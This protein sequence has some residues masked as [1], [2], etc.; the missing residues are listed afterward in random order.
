[1]FTAKEEE[2]VLQAG[3]LPESMLKANLA[4][5]LEPEI[6]EP[7]IEVPLT[8]TVPT[9]EQPV[10]ETVEVVPPK[11]KVAAK[12][13]TTIVLALSIVAIGIVIMFAIVLMT[14]NETNL[15]LRTQTQPVLKVFNGFKLYVPETMLSEVIDGELF[16]SDE[17]QTWSATITLQTGNFN[18]MISNRLQL[19][20]AYYVHGYNV[21]EPTETTIAGK[22]FIIFEVSMGSERVL[23]AY[24]R[25]SGTQIWG[26]IYRNNEAEYSAESLRELSIMLNAEESRISQGLPEG[27]T[28]EMFQET[29]K[30]SR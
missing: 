25:A 30:V 27:F 17:E 15:G 2:K 18:T 16:V 3:E 23:V 9:L 11:E 7:V 22:T 28:I 26:I 5:P 4:Q 14:A 10:K 20:D 21:E 24:T 19:T 13:T 8:P 1:M 12:L 6:V 29:F